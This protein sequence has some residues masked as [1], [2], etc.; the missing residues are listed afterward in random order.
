MTRKRR[1]V[2]KRCMTDIEGKPK[3]K[4]KREMCLA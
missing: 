3:R 2:G 1:V 4:M